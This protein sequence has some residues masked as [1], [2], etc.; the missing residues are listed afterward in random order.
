MCNFESGTV[1]DWSQDSD[2]DLNWL[3]LTGNQG[4]LDGAPYEDHTYGV[5]TGG[6]WHPNSGIT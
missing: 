5:P 6:Y 1:C 3:W 2:D 4:S